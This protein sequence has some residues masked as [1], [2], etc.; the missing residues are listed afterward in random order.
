MVRNVRSTRQQKCNKRQNMIG[1]LRDIN[2][3]TC[4]TRINCSFLDN[5]TEGYRRGELFDS[6][7]RERYDDDNSKKSYT[8][9]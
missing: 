3:Q 1:E 8:G 6:L 5:L 2:T 4:R 7:Q 9:K